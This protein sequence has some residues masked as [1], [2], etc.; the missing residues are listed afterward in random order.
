M[1]KKS[2]DAKTTLTVENAV[3]GFADASYKVEIVDTLPNGD[4]IQRVGHFKTLRLELRRK[5]IWQKE[6]KSIFGNQKL[7]KI[8]GK[9]FEPDND[10]KVYTIDATKPLT[11][12][13]RKKLLNVIKDEITKL[14]KDFPNL[15]N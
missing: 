14:S 15:F 11:P 4:K 12:A 9:Y 2:E 8:K 3:R 13:Q 10:I 1:A 7:L 5:L 6:Y